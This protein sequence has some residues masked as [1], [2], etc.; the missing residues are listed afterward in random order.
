MTGT[1]LVAKI[2]H[3]L[4]FGSLGC[5]GIREGLANTTNTMLW[6]WVEVWDPVC[7]SEALVA[8]DG[9]LADQH[10]FESYVLRDTL[11]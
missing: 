7:D 1:Y 10:T 3:H 4:I 11:C 2:Y 5:E 9:L 8:T 6:L